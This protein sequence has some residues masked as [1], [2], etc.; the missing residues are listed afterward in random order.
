MRHVCHTKIITDAF[1]AAHQPLDLPF[2][3]KDPECVPGLFFLKTVRKLK[4]LQTDDKCDKISGERT[5]ANSSA[6]DI[7]KISEKGGSCVKYGYARVSTLIQLKGNSL[8]DQR[9]KLIEAGVP[10]ENIVIEQYSGKTIQRR[11]FQNL[12][13]KLKA[14]D[15]LFCTKLDRLARNAEE[16]QRVIREL[17]E[18]NVAVYILNIGGNRHPFD[19][20]AIGKLQ[21][22]VLLAVAEFERAQIIERTA[23]GKAIAKTKAG[24]REGRPPVSKVK[25]D[26]ALEL[27][28]TKTYREV[29]AITG[30][31]RTT[32]AKYKALARKKQQ[33]L[34]KEQH[35]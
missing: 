30:L 2:Q 32:L 15:E 29:I 18:R 7:L 26:H 25:I 33:S 34:D 17:T 31:S 28:K 4:S 5:S 12:I 13:D 27:L 16:G 1:S 22:D 24:F 35:P 6:N 20:S 9:Q 14:G 11:K 8:E 23:A 10:E 3:K 19:N 21:Y